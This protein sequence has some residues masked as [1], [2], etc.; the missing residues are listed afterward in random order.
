M[1]PFTRGGVDVAL[2]GNDTHLPGPQP[3][4]LVAQPERLSDP[5]PV[6][7]SSTSRNRSRRLVQASTRRRVSPAVTVAGAL[8]A[9]AMRI[10]L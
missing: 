8:G 4:V 10:G 6:S 3:Q 9:V 7:D 1:R 5:Q 2:A